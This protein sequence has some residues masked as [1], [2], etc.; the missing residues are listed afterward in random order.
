MEAEGW[1]QYQNLQRLHE[2]ATRRVA[3]LVLLKLPDLKSKPGPNN[4]IQIKPDGHYPEQP[5]LWKVKN[6]CHVHTSK[7]ND[8]QNKARYKHTLL[9]NLHAIAITPEQMWITK[10]SSK[11]TRHK[12]IKGIEHNGCDVEVDKPNRRGR[13]KAEGKQEEAESY[14]TCRVQALQLAVAGSHVLAG[15]RQGM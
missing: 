2:A 1:V 8:Q 15:L 12:P 11:L 3:L 5:G 4:K 14:I 6:A 7:P 10:A 13:Q 9:Q